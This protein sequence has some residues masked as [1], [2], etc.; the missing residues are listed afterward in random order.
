[1]DTFLCKPE[2]FWVGVQALTAVAALAIATLGLIGLAF[3]TIYTRNMMKISEKAWQ[4]NLL[5]SLVIEV[6]SSQSGVREVTITNVGVGPGLN[7]RLWVQPVTQKFE[8]NG[9]VLVHEQNV[10]ETFLGSLLS[11]S[12]RQIADNNSSDI[13][14]LLYVVEADDLAGGSQQ[15]QLLVG[16][17][18]GER[19]TLQVRK[20]STDL[21]INWDASFIQKVLWL[22]RRSSKEMKRT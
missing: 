7:L 16:L 10:P 18:S 20:L 14:R 19:H 11:Q 15:I 13:K 9:D 17:G 5:P 1:M 8:L 6:G 21:P 4:L 3:Y 2:V 22:F 12:T